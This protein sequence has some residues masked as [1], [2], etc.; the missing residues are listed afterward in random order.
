MNC[1]HYQGKKETSTRDQRMT[2]VMENWTLYGW[3]CWK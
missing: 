3:C 2:R 1:I